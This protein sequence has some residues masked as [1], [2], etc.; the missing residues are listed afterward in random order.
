MDEMNLSESLRSWRTEKKLLQKEA[1]AALSISRVYYD[2]LEHGRARPS[3]QLFL[4]ILTAVSQECSRL[5]V[6]EE[7]S[8][9]S[10]RRARPSRESARFV[11]LSCRAG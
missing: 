4:R 11:N 3:L 8:M 2:R 10:V 6:M 9:R 7:N 1:A 5:T